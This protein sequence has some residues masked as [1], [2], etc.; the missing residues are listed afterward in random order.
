MAV[1]VHFVENPTIIV[2]PP[3]NRGGRYQIELRSPVPGLPCGHQSPQAVLWL[4]FV[5]AGQEAAREVSDVICAGC[6]PARF[7]RVQGWAEGSR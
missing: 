3:P 6:E 1:E 5:E 2:A 7:A 4:T